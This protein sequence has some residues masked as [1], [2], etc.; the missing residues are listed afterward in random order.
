MC[1]RDRPTVGGQ[2]PVLE[3]HIF[4]FSK[5]LYGQKINVE[6]L[7]KIRDEKKFDGLE[8][9]KDQIFEDIAFAKEYLS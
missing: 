7:K 1:I 5:N 3:V 9:L 4:D 8:E 2:N 6:F